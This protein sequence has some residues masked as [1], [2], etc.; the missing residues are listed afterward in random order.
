MQFVVR[1]G[2][3][4]LQYRVAAEIFAKILY[5]QWLVTAVG[6][7]K[8][9]IAAACLILCVYIIYIKNY[10]NF[11]TD[12]AASCRGKGWLRLCCVRVFGR[13]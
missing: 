2:P 1:G 12:A 5:L 9:G 13:E 3:R 4:L 6:L 8:F 7:T 11:G 10:K